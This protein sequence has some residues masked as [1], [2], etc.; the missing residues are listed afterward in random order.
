MGRAGCKPL[1]RHAATVRGLTAAPGGTSKVHGTERP[2]R[3]GGAGACAVSQETADAG[4][5]A[6][7]GGSRRA[8]RRAAE[9]QKQAAAERQRH[10][11]AGHPEETQGRGALDPTRY[12]DWEVKGVA[13]DF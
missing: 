13:S 4:G 8:A 9:R 2:F 6:R 12:G 11:A 3:P 5:R 10:G 1:L 7:A